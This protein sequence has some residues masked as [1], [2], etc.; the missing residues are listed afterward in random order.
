MRD[1]DE[2]IR[3]PPP[4]NFSFRYSADARI[5][6]IGSLRAALSK[7]EQARLVSVSLDRRKPRFLARLAVPA[8]SYRTLSL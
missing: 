8:P 4:R 3:R 6:P 1:R 7:R 5:N 2:E